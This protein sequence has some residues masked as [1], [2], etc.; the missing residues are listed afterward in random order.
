MAKRRRHITYLWT[1]LWDLV[2]WWVA[3]IVVL[4]T[5]G[6]YLAWQDGGWW[7]VLPPRDY[8]DGETIWLG[9]TLGHGGILS[10]L[11]YGTQHDTTITEYHEGVHVE[12]YEAMSLAGC[13]LGAVVAAAVCA[14][15]HVAPG[16]ALGAIVWVGAYPACLGASYLVAAARGEH[17]YLGSTFEEAARAVAGDHEG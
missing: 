2:V 16:L 7:A 12:Q 8:A 11:A 13:A 14:I 9:I 17:I 3:S 10:A 1:W 4:C 15:G 5:R 6:A